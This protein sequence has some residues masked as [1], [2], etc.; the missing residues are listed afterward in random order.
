M[1]RKGRG[2][3]IVILLL[4]LLAVAAALF[5]PMTGDGLG[6]ALNMHFTFF[7]FCALG[8]LVSL[9]FAGSVIICWKDVSK[10]ERVLAFSSFAFPVFSYV[11]LTMLA[12]VFL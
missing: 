6:D 12:A 1:S 3:V 8:F 11:L 4:N 2:F 7:A 5:T 9:V 10:N